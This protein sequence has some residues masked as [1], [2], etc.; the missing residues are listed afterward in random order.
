MIALGS[1]ICAN[2]N[3]CYFN[4]LHNITMLRSELLF[5]HNYVKE[6]NFELDLKMSVLLSCH[7]GVI[8]KTL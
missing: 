2:G 1:L 5:V 4:V 6:T 3:I 7:V 8:K